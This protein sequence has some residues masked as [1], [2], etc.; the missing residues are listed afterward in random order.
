MSVSIQDSATFA[1]TTTIIFICR[2]DDPVNQRILA[3]DDVLTAVAV[4]NIN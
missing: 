2:N 4:D 1:Q 3:N